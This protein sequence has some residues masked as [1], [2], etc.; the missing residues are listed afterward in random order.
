MRLKII[1][2]NCFKRNSRNL[3]VVMVE[4]DADRT[5]NIYSYKG[6]FFYRY[7]QWRITN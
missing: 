7:T 6:L 5:I 2:M 1:R 3:P 4:S